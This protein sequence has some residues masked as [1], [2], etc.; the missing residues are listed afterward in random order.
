MKLLDIASLALDSLQRR[1]LRSW[2]AILGIVIGVA[3]IISLIS[4]S[5]G[6]TDSVQSQFSGLGANLVTISS[7]SARAERMSMPGMGGGAPQGFG[8]SSTSQNLT[9]DDADALESL[10]NVVAVDARVQSRATISFKAKNYSATIIG[11]NSAAFPASSAITIAEGRTLEPNEDSSVVVGYSLGY[12]TFNTT[13]NESLLDKKIKING[14]LFKVVGILNQSG[15]SMGGGVDSEVFMT[16]ERAKSMFDISDPSSIIVVAASESTADTVAGNATAVL[17]DRHGVTTEN[18]D[19]QISTASTLKST[20]T[21]VTSTL[22]LFLGIISSISL[23]V[24]GIGVANAMFT[25]VL[26]QTRY[27]GILAALGATKEDITKLFLFE[28]GM[29]GLIGG[30]LGVLLSFLISFL[31]VT[32]GMSSRIELWLVALGMGF[33]VLIGIVSGAFPALNAASI[34]PVEAL[35]YE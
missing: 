28:S 7:G 25:S 14:T 10:D 9:F 13:P 34:E 33:S 15:T 22:T 20:L 35:R 5:I 4:V 21:S 30:T 27:I 11:V 16:N 23:F 6:T 8:S 1:K 31:M 29:V 2:L 18:Q 17:L 12:T 3:S 24:G 19:F 32:F 26:E